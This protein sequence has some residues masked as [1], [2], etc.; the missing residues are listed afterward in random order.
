MTG[1]I[2]HVLDFLPS[3]PPGELITI[4]RI[5]KSTAYISIVKLLKLPVPASTPR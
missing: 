2:S 1:K 3:A 5:D 4:S